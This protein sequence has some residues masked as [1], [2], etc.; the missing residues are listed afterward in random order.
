MR[1]WIL[2]AGYLLLI[3]SG[4][5]AQ[6]GEVRGRITDVLSNEPMPFVNVAV[7]G[8]GI[9]TITDSLGNFRLTGLTPG[10]VRIQASFVGYHPVMSPEI[11]V[12]KA[13]I[14]AVELKMERQDISLDEV[15]VNA[16]PFR[17]TEES[18]VSL[19]TIGIAEIEKS[20]GANRD[21]S[22]V[23]QSF[24]GV[25][26]TPAYRNDIIIRGG[27]PSESRFYLDGVEVPNIN[28]FATQGASGGPVGILNADFLREVNYYSGAFPANRGNALSGV[29]EFTQ[30]DGNP[31]KLKFRGTLGA[32][33]L[34]ATVDGPAG[35]KTTFIVSAR[36][37]YLK[38]LF[39]ALQLPFLPTFNDMQFKVR[40][41]L[42][43][44]NE[45]TFIGLGAIDLFD[46]NRDIKNPDEQQQ[47]ILSY[48]PKNE[49]WS[50]TVG[51]V[52]KHFRDKSYQTL[53][54]SR[55]HLNN[56]NIK[57][58]ENDESSENNKI[59]DYHSQ[60]TENK[61]RLENSLRLGL[62]KLNMGANIDFSTYTNTTYQRRFYEGGI[63]AVNY[64][65][66]L[67]LVKWGLF[68]QAS[69]SFLQER[70]S[71][72]AGVRT[73]AV[74][75]SSSM[76][77][78][79]KQLSP[80]F[81]ASYLFAPS[82]SVNFNTGRYFQLPAY[83]TL[84]YKED[85]VLVNKQ[86]ELKYI[87]VDHLIGGI[88]Y[89]PAQSM[90]FSVEGFLKQYGHYP[91]S[92][93]DQISLANKGADYGVIG[94][95]KVVSTSRGRAYGVEFQARIKSSKGF[96]LNL[97]YTLVRSEFEDRNNRYF[98]SSWDSKHILSL[99]GSASLK[100][101]WRIGSRFRYVGG[102]PYTPY[103]LQNSSLVQVW[104]L[105]GGPIT[106]NSR[107]N[108]ERFPAF[109]QLDVRVDKAY[110]LKRMT[111]RFYVDIQNLYNFQAKSQDIVVREQDAQG[112]YLTVDNGTRYVLR[113][114]DNTSGTVLP[115]I[116]VQ[117]EF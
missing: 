50:Y 26:S 103:D 106:D 68:A 45:I 46:L 43:E 19:K 67:D 116:G 55:S 90:L 105:R 63:Q 49:Q 98:V 70:L 5:F 54:V 85:G 89:Q 72:S 12:S 107:L 23:I 115:T 83:T 53:V 37:S 48:I 93:N 87:S 24:A 102:L 65:T 114:V 110:Y 78:M 1:S 11:E 29:F 47:Y 33:E 44:K 17:K 30:V 58:L 25:L 81:S 95:E 111:L 39:S 31:D 66:S 22:R 77:N 52:Y 34:S 100:K 57:Y 7:A 16:S 62:F 51:G 2:T 99:T 86:N 96:N 82:W 14:A 92:V 32:S 88:E 15:T 109:H 69:H 36:R 79:L 41:R 4:L 84:G 42:N 113:T 64:D 74:N 97:S 75:Y 10:F 9:G 35:E 104:N 27:G 18:P 6:Q 3:A 71:L 40:T 101:N 73:D 59:L 28:H 112:N 91:F 38:L 76:N 94:D 21:V 20:P 61:I 117:V 8:T 108:A 56:A 60:E 13:N 80:R